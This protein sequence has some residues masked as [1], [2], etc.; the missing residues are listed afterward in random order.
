MAEQDFENEEIFD[1]KAEDRPKFS[2]QTVNDEICCGDCVL[3]KGAIILG[4]TILIML[5]LG[6][7]IITNYIPNINERRTDTH[8]MGE[9]EPE[10][11]TCPKKRDF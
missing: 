1:Y 11:R 2:L 9:V 5:S 8:P 7:I 10:T 4:V 3:K 6:E